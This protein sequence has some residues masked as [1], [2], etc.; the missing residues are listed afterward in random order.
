[1][2]FHDDR[3]VIL[4]ASPCVRI[5][6]ILYFMGLVPHKDVVSAI[7]RKE[8]NLRLQ[9]KVQN[10]CKYTETV[11]ISPH[12][13]PNGAV[14]PELGALFAMRFDRGVAS[15]GAWRSRVALQFTVSPF[16]VYFEIPG[17]ISNKIVICVH[18]NLNQDGY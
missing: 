2:S 13:I 8:D 6:L 4:F 16:K 7:H 14:E 18:F 11:A 3:F 15:I 9:R 10:S 5:F 12:A 1:M 17:I